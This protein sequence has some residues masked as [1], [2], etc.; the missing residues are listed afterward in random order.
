MP[1][2]ASNFKSIADATTEP[3]RKAYLAGGFGLSLLT[4]GAILML[5][6]FFL[7]H[8]D[9][10]TY[11]LLSTGVF[12]VLFTVLYVYFKELHRLVKVHASIKSNKELIDTVQRTAVELTG[13]ASDLQALAFKH[14]SEVSAAISL[15]RPILSNVPL[16][17]KLL[18]S[19]AFTKAQ[20]L[21]SAIVVTT[22][23]ARKVIDDLRSALTDANAEH[24]KKYLADIQK[25]HE[26]VENLLAGNLGDGARTESTSPALWTDLLTQN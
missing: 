3:L 4:L 10:I 13:L 18:D 22:Q 17:S 15:A 6:A 21:S 7:N 26:T 24:L 11:V 1:T 9:V 19:E 23:K 14:A 5:T 12:L 20:L 2:S 25:Y 8:R 16:I